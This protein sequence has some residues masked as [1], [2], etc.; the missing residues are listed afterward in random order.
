MEKLLLKNGKIY[1][2]RN[3]FTHAL[4]I[5]EG[6]IKATGDSALLF[7]PQLSAGEIIDVEGKTVVP[8]FNDSH[9][10]FYQTGLAM[11]SLSLHDARSIE[12][13]V[14]RGRTYLNHQRYPLEILRGRGFHQD[15]FEEKRLPDKN[16]LD[17]ISTEIPIVFTRTCSHLA[18]VNSKALEFLR[19]NS[20]LEEVDSG[21]IVR[22]VDGEPNGIFKENAIALLGHLYQE[23]S[24][25]SV[26]RVLQKTAEVAHSYGITSLQVNDIW[27]SGSDAAA[28]EKA[29]HLFAEDKVIRI[30]H[31]VCFRDLNQFELSIK[32]GFPYKSSAWNRYGA[33]KLFADGSLGAR[34][35]FLRAPYEDDSSTRGVLT[36][37]E[38]NIILYLKACEAANIRS[39]IHCIGDGALE[40]LL[41]CYEKTIARGNPLRHGLIH[42]Q[43]TDCQLLEKIK[44]LNLMVYV[45]PIFIH[46]DHAVVEHRVGRALA[47]TSYAFGSMEKLGIKVAYSSD[48]PIENFR[49]MENL[50]CAVTRKDLT[51][52]PKGGFNKDEAVD[53]FQALD[54]ITINSAYME[55]CE[56][57]KGRLSEGFEADLVVLNQPYF[58]VDEEEIK[59]ITVSKTLVHGRI[60]YE[61]KEAYR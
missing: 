50:Y 11:E 60:V 45:Q 53:R 12:E 55:F 22:G 15:L 8:G 20:L 37:E 56:N 36:I 13:L 27:Y 59:N 24:E 41:S 40:L 33:L 25:E 57:S 30:S 10:H 21:E 46:S 44:A 17:L 6:I 42:V 58:D 31:Q 39:L 35:A 32:K 4:Y 9:L 23:P 18:V 28:I 7:E 19:T 54:N 26:L 14:E 1:Q 52:A 3:K 5:E 49:V 61:A 47:K 2:Q 34:T 51:G 29:Y 43:I 48:A 16:D 38:E